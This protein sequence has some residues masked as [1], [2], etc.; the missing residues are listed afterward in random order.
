MKE[1]KT[2][3][4][5]LNKMET[6]N[7]LDVEFKTLV[8]RLLNKLRENFKGHENHKKQPVK[9]T[10]MKNNLQGI[11]SRVYEAERQISDWEYKEAKNTQSKQHP[12]QK[13]NPSQPKWRPR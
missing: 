13:K 9:I 6:S 4:K 1:H 5:Q 11:N 2:P 10:D 12:P 8:I 7:L 3:E